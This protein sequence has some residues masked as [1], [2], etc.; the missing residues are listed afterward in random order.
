MHAEQSC[1]GCYEALPKIY[2][3]RASAEFVASNWHDRPKM[4]EKSGIASLK[5]TSR[6]VPTYNGSRGIMIKSRCLI[7]GGDDFIHMTLIRG[8][9]CSQLPRDCRGRRALGGAAG[10][11]ITSVASGRGVASVTEFLETGEDRLQQ[12]GV[13]VPV[14]RTKFTKTISKISLISNRGRSLYT[15]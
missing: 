10:K 12:N 13:V 9:Y 15:E 3:S 5:I 2:R 7:C 1:T 14:K 4:G 8:R 11:K 6:M